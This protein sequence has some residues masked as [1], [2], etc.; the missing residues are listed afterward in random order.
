[1]DQDDYI[2]RTMS[3]PQYLAAVD[4]TLH[5]IGIR[6]GDR[7]QQVRE[8]QARY[9]AKKRA[10]WEWERMIGPPVLA[11]AEAKR[12]AHLD[13]MQRYLNKPGM[14]EARRKY[15]RDYNARK[16]AAGK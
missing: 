14:R 10:D 15:A 4:T 9:R 6:K 3:D 5:V 12:K 2:K 8:A 11:D 1:M 7:K 13:A 16:K